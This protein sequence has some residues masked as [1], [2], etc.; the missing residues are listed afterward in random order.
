MELAG[1]HQSSFG[2]DNMRGLPLAPVDES[3][4]DRFVNNESRVGICDR[5]VSIGRS[6][7]QLKAIF[8]YAFSCCCRS[9]MLKKYGFSASLRSQQ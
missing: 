5:G 4:V 8:H 9:S 3:I 2:V 1:I 7:S 6:C